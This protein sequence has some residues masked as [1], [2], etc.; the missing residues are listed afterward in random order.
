MNRRYASVILILFL[1]FLSACAGGGQTGS[2]AAAD[3]LE[4]YLQALADKDEA[5]LTTRVCPEF[6]ADA[7]LE[8]DAFQG[9]ETE[10]ADLNCAE[11]GSRDGATLVKC[12][13]KILASYGNEVQEFDLGDR[14]YQMT[15]AGE[16]WQVCGYRIE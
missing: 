13:G 5:G 3:T 8:F 11:T 10:L 15:P 16:D 9:V 1:L 12:Q 2:S 7:L 6:E 4:S 14:T